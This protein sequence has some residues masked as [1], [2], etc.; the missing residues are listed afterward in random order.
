MFLI[1]Y[2]FQAVMPKEGMEEGRRSMDERVSED[3]RSLV[4]SFENESFLS[5]KIELNSKSVFD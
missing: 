2:K 3:T 1:W 4:H 5:K